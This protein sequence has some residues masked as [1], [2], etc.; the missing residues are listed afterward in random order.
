MD[1]LIDKD[2]LRFLNGH[3]GNN[4]AMAYIRCSDFA[5]RDM[6]RT[7]RFH[8]KYDE[9]AEIKWN[10]RRNVTALIKTQV[11]AWLQIPPKDQ[12]EFNG[13]H[14]K[15]CE[16]IIVIYQGIT[17]QMEKDQS[18]FFGQAQKWVN[19]TLKNL[20]VY[21]KSNE[22]DMSFDEILPYL[23]I[24]LDN[25][26]MDIASDKKKCYI[27]PSDQKYGVSKPQT[28][29]SRM[30]ASEYQAYQKELKAKIGAPIPLLWEL[31]HWSTVIE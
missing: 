24:P 27:D 2:V 7:I 31:T 13:Q 30:D 22:T 18:L 3:L 11:E 9:D 25:V 12:D 8:K 26:I 10:L 21:S 5:Y 6:C 15:L 23:H 4:D 14:Q 16:K 28:A 19:M 1:F 29:W 17:D 20:Y